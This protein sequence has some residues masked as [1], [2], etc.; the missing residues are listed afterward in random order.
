MSGRAG[1]AA[2]VVRGGA[3]RCWAQRS[4]YAAAWLFLGVFVLAGVVQAVLPAR[5][6]AGLLWWASTDVVNLH[7]DPADCL[8]AS[9]FL[10]EGGFLG[11]VPLIGLALFGANRAVGNARLVLVCTAGQVIGTLASEGI[12][13]YRVSH[14]LLPAAGDRIMDVGP[15]YVVVSAIVVAVLCGS[16][17]ARLAA[18]VDLAVLVV[19]GNIF[20]GLTTLGVAAVGHTTAITVALLAAPLLM[21]ARPL[22]SAPAED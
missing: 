13:D 10:P 21:R 20:G 11:W 18:A 2:A 14:G 9:A 15:S 22:V 16:R 6:A 1:Q 8:I 7:R 19:A 12:Q 4:R 3:A 5:E 17:V